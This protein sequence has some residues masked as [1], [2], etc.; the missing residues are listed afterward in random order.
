VEITNTFIAKST[1]VPIGVKL[2]WNSCETNEPGILERPL[3]L[4][5]RS[6][7]EAKQDPQIGF[8]LTADPDLSEPI[9]I[10]FNVRFHS[11][12]HTLV[13]LL[14]KKARP[15]LS[16][17]LP[18]RFIKANIRQFL[19]RLEELRFGISPIVLYF[20]PISAKHSR[21]FR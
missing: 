12:N 6:G 15:A 3:I 14:R 8:R 18:C 1:F 19:Q 21:V 4:G 10:V 13:L 17:V 7:L 11:L 2:R 9:G 5:S 16:K 20:A